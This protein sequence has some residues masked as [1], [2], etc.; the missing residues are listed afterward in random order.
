MPVE[1][2]DIA[3]RADPADGLRPLRATRLRLGPRCDV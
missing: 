1:V 2:P 3:W